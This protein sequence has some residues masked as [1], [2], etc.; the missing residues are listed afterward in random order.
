M[1]RVFQALIDRSRALLDLD[2]IKTILG[3]RRRPRYRTRKRMSAEWDV[4]VEKPT[5]DLTIF[6]LH[7]G[8][9]TLKIYTKGER[10]LRIEAMAHNVKELDCGRNLEKFPRIIAELKG[11]LE[12]FMQALSCVDQ[13]FIPDDTLEHLPEPSTV[14]KARVGGIDFNKPRMRRVAEAVLALSWRPGGFNSS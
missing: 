12:R 9:L 1:E 13:C 6:R 8:K 3:Y 11:I 5:Y 2:T 14:G 7:C 4:T 10:V